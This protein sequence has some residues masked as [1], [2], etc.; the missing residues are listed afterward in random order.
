MSTA[1]DVRT[2]VYQAL[3]VD[4]MIDQD[5]IV[6]DVVNGDVSLNGT[7]P[8]QAQ[9]S[10]ATAA[11]ERVAGVS[12]V[13]N[14]LDVALPSAD[15]GDDAALAG[16]AEE[17][18]KASSGVPSGIKVTAQEGNIFLTG[19]VSSSAERAAAESAVA[20]VGGALSVTND[21]VVLRSSG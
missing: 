20:G 21:I 5:D 9:L 19:A 13:Y 12:T 11:A 18:L 8:S 4:P 3:K 14:L 16:T 15:Y 17:A 2:A 6:V 7:V 10:E 1:S